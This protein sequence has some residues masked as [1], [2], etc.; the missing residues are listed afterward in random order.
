M[1]MAESSYNCSVSQGFNFEK[2]AQTL[3]GHIVACKV[4][5]TQFDADLNVTNPEDNAN[6]V[7][8]FGIVSGI[9]W[10]GGYADPVQF[11]CQVSTNNKNKIATLV[12]K[13]MAN[14]EVL[15]QFNIYDYDPKEKK[16]Y[17][18]F[19]SNATDLKGLVLKSGW[20]VGH[21]N[22]HGPVHGSR[23]AEELQLFTGRDAAG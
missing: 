9:F 18:C 1:K 3:V 23:L 4:G 8:V 6:L 19:H 13:S 15:F 2:D 12:H 10:N 22:R 5:D 11:T 20:R 17:K 14:T 16:Y 21:A 7:K